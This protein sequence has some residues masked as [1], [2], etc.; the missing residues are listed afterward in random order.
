MSRSAY[1][2]VGFPNE[3]TRCPHRGRA[4]AGK[5][6]ALVQAV[7]ARFKNQAEALATDR[8]RLAK[9][10]FSGGGDDPRAPWSVPLLDQLFITDNGT[11]C[12]AVAAKISA[13]AG[14]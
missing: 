6:T 14:Q 4:G 5:T 11:L 8:A 2:D 1:Y 13:L 12:E 10:G 3:P 7:F 9:L